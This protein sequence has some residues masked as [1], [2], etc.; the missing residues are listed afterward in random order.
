MVAL[1]VPPVTTTAA[2]VEL[3][4]VPPATV[5]GPPLTLVS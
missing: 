2:P 5:S 4:I 1:G 3:L